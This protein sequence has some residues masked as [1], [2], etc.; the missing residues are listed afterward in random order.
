[1]RGQ[2]VGDQTARAERQLDLT[3]GGVVSVAALI[4]YSVTLRGD[5]QA[6]DAGELQIAAWTLSIP[7]PPGYPLYTLL[8]WMAS[9]LPIG[10]SPYLR[11]SLLSA[12]TSALGAGLLAARV[13]G[14]RPAGAWTGRLAGL[15][16]GLALATSV[17]FWAQATTANIRSLTALFSVGLVAAGVA[18]DLARRIGAEGGSRFGDARANLL[19]C[20]AVLG[21]GDG[22]HASLVF[23]GAVVGL[24]VLTAYLRTP[25]ARTDRVRGLLAA[26]SVLVTCQV[27]WLL[28]PL[29]T[30]VPSPL[31]H[32][33]LASLNGF[34]DHALARG[35]EGDFFY[36]VRVV[37]ERLG[38]RLGLLPQL[39]VFQFS[40]A[41]L[42]VMAI[43]WVGLIW[44]R[45]ALGLTLAGA[46]ALHLFITLTYRA[47]QTVEYALPAWVIAVAGAGLGIAATARRGVPIALGAALLILASGDGISR[48]SSFALLTAD[49]GDRGM[50]EAALAVTPQNGTILGQWHQISPIWALQAIEGIR[51]DVQA[52]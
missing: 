7:H 3:V 38:D 13:A 17:T 9:H 27:V 26:A 43:G 8:A 22:H 25:A 24:F 15:G 12:L 28:L 40:P 11:I 21:L 52:R 30:D 20:A 39:F 47:P 51:P 14:S 35:F 18:A 46:M 2:E 5:V 36:F 45:T 49:R 32:G 4:L 34:L 48:F 19:V 1:M 37:P 44:R 31:D 50:A 41:A 29:R 33:N 6:A 16:A 10:A 23:P 42:A